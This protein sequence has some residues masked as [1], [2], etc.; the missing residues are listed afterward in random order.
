MPSNATADAILTALR[1]M[2][3]PRVAV[4]VREI[5]DWPMFPVECEHANAAPPRRRFEF[6]SG[7]ALLRDLMGMDVPI[8]VGRDRAP[9]LPPDVCGSLAHDEFFVVAAVGRTSDF[10]SIGID[11]EPV[12]PLDDE[13]AEVIVRSDEGGI[14]AHLAFTLKEAAYK[15]WS[16]LGGGM[17]EHHDV[18]VSTSTPLFRAEI[19]TAQ[20]TLDGTFATVGGR[21]LALVVVNNSLS[22]ID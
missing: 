20:T 2:A 7:R 19:V 3:P 17:L 9:V 6:A 12:E 4:G 10:R 15:A 18:R 5:S 14:D 11:I 1:A 16:G 21:W 13:I 8:P 22:A